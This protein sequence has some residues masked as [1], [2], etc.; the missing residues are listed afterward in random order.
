MCINDYCR[1]KVPDEVLYF[2]VNVSVADSTGLMSKLRLTGDYALQTLGVTVSDVC[3]EIQLSDVKLTIPSDLQPEKFLAMTTEGKQ[4][5]EHRYW[6][7]YVEMGIL[8]EHRSNG[9]KTLNILH[10]EPTTFA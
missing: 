6:L 7:E 9:R 3:I 5:I 10:M 4:Q 8:I 1:D 2:D